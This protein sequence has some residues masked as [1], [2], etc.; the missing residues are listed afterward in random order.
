[1]S[2]KYKSMSLK[3]EPWSR[4][5]HIDGAGVRGKSVAQLTDMLLG[6][7]GSVPPPILSHRKCL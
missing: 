4:V 6:E 2:L 1:M 3:Y 5:T 7:D